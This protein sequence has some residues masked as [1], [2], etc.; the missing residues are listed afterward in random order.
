MRSSDFS[1][2]SSQKLFEPIAASLGTAIVRMLAPDALA[3]ARME[4]SHVSVSCARLPCETAPARKCPF[5]KSAVVRKSKLS[6][7]RASRYKNWPRS[8]GPR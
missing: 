1:S 6:D 2:Q 4:P 3:S 5:R 8:I 7:H